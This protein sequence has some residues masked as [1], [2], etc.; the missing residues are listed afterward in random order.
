MGMWFTA[1]ILGTP[2]VEI[3]RTTVAGQSQQIF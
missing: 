3:R 2:E 1:K